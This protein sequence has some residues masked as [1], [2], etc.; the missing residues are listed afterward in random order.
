MKAP[1]INGLDSLK[2]LFPN[3]KV[4]QEYIIE[5]CYFFDRETVKRHDNQIKDNIESNCS[6]PRLI[7][8]LRCYISLN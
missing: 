8:F 6:I 1:S 4:L 7:L 2:A 3:E 5:N